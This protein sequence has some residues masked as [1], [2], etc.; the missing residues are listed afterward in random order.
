MSHANQSKRAT[1]KQGLQLHRR[2]SS[3]IGRATLA[4]FI[5]IAGTANAQ[6]K[7]VD[8]DANKTLSEIDKRIGDGNLNK[9]VSDLLKEVRTGVTNLGFS[10][11][12][13]P[14]NQLQKITDTAGYIQQACPTPGGA[15]AAGADSS[16]RTV[17]SIVTIPAGDPSSTKQQI[18]QQL[19]QLRVQAFNETI[20]MT[21]RFQ[22][23]STQLNSIETNRR[24]AKTL[25]DLWANTNES[26]RTIGKLDAEMGFW[27]TRLSAYESAIKFHEG[28]QNALTQTAIKGSSGV[29][30]RLIQTVALAAA[31]A[32]H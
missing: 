24:S 28:Q 1:V 20:D 22:Q 11:T 23:Y 27:R 19:I 30:A 26:L 31:L 18:C 9:S 29:A 12:L 2:L 14:E 7:V 10:A 32:I 5:A 6:W 21:N 16:G 3:N 13:T 17:T 4:L 15:A 25:G 8:E